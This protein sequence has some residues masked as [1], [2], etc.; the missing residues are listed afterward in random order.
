MRAL[1][2]NGHISNRAHQQS[3]V[4]A[5]AMARGAARCVSQVHDRGAQAVARGAARCASQA[6]GSGAQAVASLCVAGT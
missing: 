2:V 6:I 5:Q 3:P 1:V 4:S